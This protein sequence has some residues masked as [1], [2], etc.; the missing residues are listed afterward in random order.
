MQIKKRKN[1]ATHHE[2]TTKTSWK[3][4][5]KNN[6]LKSWKP[7]KYATHENHVN[8][9]KIMKIDTKPIKNTKIKKKRKGEIMKTIMNKQWK[10]HE[11]SV[12]KNNRTTIKLMNIKNHEQ[13]ENNENLKNQLTIN[14]SS[15][16]QS[17]KSKNNNKSLNTTWKSPP[18]KIV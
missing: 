16:K 12:K 4:N 8:D 10:H 18:P 5:K 14:Q 9:I 3:I 11:T 17:W 2:R 7:K 1:H 6:D 13:H 15:I